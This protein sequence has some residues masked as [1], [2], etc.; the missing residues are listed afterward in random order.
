M[1]IV[2]NTKGSVNGVYCDSA[3]SSSENPQLADYFILLSEVLG[4]RIGPGGLSEGP[5]GQPNVADPQTQ[6]ILTALAQ[7]LTNTSTTPNFLSDLAAG[8]TPLDQQLETLLNQTPPYGGPSMLQLLQSIAAEGADAGT[9]VNT[10]VGELQDPDSLPSQFMSALNNA[11]LNYTYEGTATQGG[12]FSADLQL[13]AGIGGISGLLDTIRAGVQNGSPKSF[14]MAQ[15]AGAALY[16][17]IDDLDID[18]A[19]APNDPMSQFLVSLL[20]GPPVFGGQS[21]M[22]FMQ[23][24]GI[25]TASSNLFNLDTFYDM[26]TGF[27]D[28]SFNDFSISN[29]LLKFANVMIPLLP[30]AP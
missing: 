27:H 6:Y 19:A 12:V 15:N 25:S 14:S 30:P 5:S 10:L 26:L 1:E 22:A 20:N 9:A 11:S 2:S 28:G 13:F 17:L 18:A 21:L 23:S 4:G 24:S 16:D 29:V 8:T 3:N 7:M